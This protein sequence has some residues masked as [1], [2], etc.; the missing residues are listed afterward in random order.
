MGGGRFGRSGIAGRVLRVFWI[1]GFDWG[2]GSDNVAEGW[3]LGNWTTG[4]D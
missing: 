1:E 2:V 4:P 3:D